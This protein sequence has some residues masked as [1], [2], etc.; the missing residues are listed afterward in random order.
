MILF[1]VEHDGGVVDPISLQALTAARRVG[2]VEAVLVALEPGGIPETLKRFGVAKVHHVRDERLKSYSPEAIGL[3]L[4]QACKAANAEAV[5]G[6]GTEKGN[7][8]MTYAAAKLG[9]PLANNAVQITPGEKWTVVRQRWGGGLLEESTLP[10]APRILTVAPQVIAPEEAPAERVELIPFKPDLNESAFR[11]RVARI[12]K[13]DPKGQGLKTAKIVVGGGRGVGGPDGF[14]CLEELAAAIGAVVGGSR[15]AI[16]NGWRP[17]TDQIGLTGSRITP[18]LY[19]ACGI[20]GAIQHRAG[21]KGA[22]KILVINKDKDAPFFTH[23]D[24]GVIGDLHEV[25]PAVTRA[26]KNLA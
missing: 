21:C 4:A 19:I 25:V 15:V 26:Y 7:E 12:E 17:P 9:L 2:T 23:A 22:E 16:N 13:F 6:P 3:C 24:W 10:A 11:V 8:V 5:I 20:S 18:K 14:K 1:Y